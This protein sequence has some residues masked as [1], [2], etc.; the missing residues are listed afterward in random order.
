MNIYTSLQNNVYDSLATLFPD[1][2]IVQ[3]YTNGPEPR[4]PYIV[5][6]LYSVKQQGQEY[7]ETF[8]SI[9]GRQQIYSHYSCLIRLE[10]AAPTQ[11]FR[12]AELANE[13][14]FIVDYTTSQEVFLKNN[15]S[16]LRKS[17]IRKIPKKRDTDWWM[18]YQIDLHFGYQVEARQDTGVIE[19]V[20][21]QGGYVR[22]DGTILQ[23]QNQI[24]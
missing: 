13:L 1:T 11:D 21:I 18:F 7:I 15:L 14:Y 4:S 24:P 22:E 5:F 6:D 9:E 23:T 10:F 3:A 20:E 8:T 16:Y 2:T 17:S 12:A 19:S